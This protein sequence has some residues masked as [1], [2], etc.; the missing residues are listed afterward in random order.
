MSRARHFIQWIA[1]SLCVYALSTSV[2]LAQSYS[3]APTT[4]SWIDSGTHTDVTW[5][6]GPGCPAPVDDDITAQI[7]LGFTFTFGS[8]DYT[9]VQIQSNGRLQFNNSYCTYGTATVGPPPTYPDPYPS[10]NLNNTMRVYGADLNPALGGTVRYATLG[11]APNRYFVVTW[12]NIREWTQSFSGFNLQI[13]IYENGDF[14]YQYGA[15]TNPSGG[16]GDIGWQLS[17]TDYTSYSFT[18]ITALANSAIRFYRNGYLAYYAAD[19]SSWNGTAGEVIDASGAGHSGVRVGSAQ[20]TAAGHDCRAADIPA[21]SSTATIS[22]INTGLDANTNIGN[23][24]TIEF[25]YRANAAW[26]GG[27]DRVLFDASSTANSTL[28]YAVVRNTGALNFV[29]QKSTGT[30]INFSTAA[31]GIAAGTWTHVALTWNFAGPSYKIYINGA[32]ATSSTASTAGSIANL[33]TLY[34]G[35]NRGT[36][37]GSGANTGT[38][39]SADGRLDEVR[40]Y[41]YARTLAQVQFDKGLTHVCPGIDHFTITHDGYGINCAIEPITVNARDGV[42]GAFSGYNQQITL[43]TGSGKGDWTLITGGG[44]LSN[45]TANDGIATYQWV[46]TDT[47]AVFG[48]SYKEGAATINI[49]VYQS[50]A[51]SIRDDDTEGTMTWTPSGFVVTSSPLSNP[52]PGVIPTFVSPQIAATNFTMYLTAYG[53]TPTDTQCGVIEAYTGAKNLKFWSAYVN[54]A[55]GTRN[56]TINAGNIA[57]SEGA[58]AAQAVTFTNGQASVTARYADAGAINI[59]LKDDTTGNPSLPTGIRGST[60]NIVVRPATFVLSNIKRTS[61]NFANPSANTASGAVFMAAGQA[62][63]ATVTAQDSTGAPTPNF[64][65]ESIPESIALTSALV[66]PAGGQNSSVASAVGF[67]VFTNG[68]ATGTDFSWPEVGI[69]TLTP[70]IKDGDYLGAGD[71]VG[72][73]SSN[74]GRFIPNDFAVAQNTP[75]FQTACAAGAFTY[76]GQPFVYATAPVLTVTARAFGGATTRNYT[77]SLLKL[78]NASITGRTYS[79]VSATLDTSGVPAAAADPTIADLTNGLASLTFSA[80]SGIAIARSSPV[81]PFNA[82]ISLGINVIDSDGVTASNPITFSNIAFS[83]GSEQRYGRI[84][85]RNAVGSELLNLPVPMHSEYFV[86]TTTG[87]TQNSG[88]SCTT[89][90]TMSFANYGGNLSSGETCMLDTGSPG[91]SGIGCAVAASPGQQFKMPPS[92]GDFVAIL[93]APGAGNDGTVTVTTV[94]PSWLRF[95]WN[96]AAPGLENPSGVATFGIFRGE[97]KRIFQTEK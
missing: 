84:A 30:V 65:K 8:V 77:G 26:T 93:R 71:V 24:G 11:T 25:W 56:V 9:Q 19:E 55:T 80:G 28:F 44:T 27:G 60:G 40:I 49:S 48:L 14:V 15:Q 33:D 76:I 41:S 21:N 45:G 51:S 47:S 13:I 61:D 70:H 95:D 36:Y 39:N 88:D 42:N 83:N 35:D 53:T 7:P 92:A 12:T 75:S 10:G 64:G 1:L 5:T 86:N 43:D 79:A 34:L 85:F 32:L 90:V 68:V 81:A 97:T 16:K 50:S 74:V 3:N 66:L 78:T 31:Q 89:G 62:F 17:T 94:V 59:A 23:A 67:G 20:T 29:L 18:S 2:A 73:T 69:I 58:S 72:T 91:V 82:Q 38:G 4:Y 63:T 52:P 87:F 57:T 54:P 96:A 37:I 6:N 46:S 22:A